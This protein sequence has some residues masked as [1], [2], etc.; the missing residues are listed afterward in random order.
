MSV[1]VDDS[2]GATS[3]DLSA[4][5]GEVF[6]FPASYAQRRLWF[7]DRYEPGSPL[8]NIPLAHRL[9]GPL[10]AAALAGALAEIVRRHEALRTTLEQDP[11]GPVQVVAPFSGSHP[12][13]W[14]D[15]ARLPAGSRQDEA[16]RLVAEE[17]SRPFDLERGPLFRTVLLRLGP[18]EHVLLANFHHAIADGWSLGVFH[19]ELAALYAAFRAGKPSPLADLPIQYADFSA[20]QQEWLQ[21][22]VLETQLAYW[23]E[24]LAGAPAVLELPSDPPRPAVR[25]HRGAARSLLLP[26]RLSGAARE[27]GHRAR[28]TRF[29][30]LL[31]AWKVLLQR[32]SGQ[33]DLVVGT[34]IA[35]RNQVETE[36]LIGLFVNTLALRTGLSGDPAFLEAVTRVRDT[37]LE[38]YAHQDLPFERLVEELRPERDLAH[39]PLVQVIFGLREPSERGLALPGLTAESAEVRHEAVK[40][41]LALSLE[42]TGAGLLARL[43]YSTDL[44]DGAAAT[45]WLESLAALLEGVAADPARPLGALPAFPE[46]S[47]HQMLVEWNDTWS[48]YPRG[49]TVHELFAAQVDRT[50]KA[51]AVESAEELL[52]YGEVNARANRLAHHLTG[53]GVGPE[54][55]VGLCLNRSVEA[56]VAVLGVLKAGGAYVPLDPA[57]PRERLAWMMADTA[58]PVLLS[59]SRHAAGLPE[60]GPG[61]RIVLLDREKGAIDRQSAGD[62]P[63][64]TAPEGLA[65]VMYTSGST[66]RSKGVAVCH[67]SVVR[68]VRETGYARFAGETFLQFAPIAF[69]ASTLE[70]WGPLLNGGRLAVFP[71]YAPSLAELGEAIERHGVTAL[72]LTAGLFHQM[73]EGPVASLRNVRQL[74]AGGDVLSPPHVAKALDEIPGVTLVNGYGP[75]ENTTF[76]C[77]YPMR[78]PRRSLGSVPVGRPIA[79]SRIALLDRN[80][81]P[82]PHGAP[83]E[84]CAGGDGLARGYLGRP[85]LTAEKFIPDPAASPAEPGARLYRTGDLARFRAD[86]SVE[87]LGRIDTQ[88]KVRGFRIELG[89]IEAHLVQHPAVRE[90]AVTAREDLPGSRRLVA[91]IVPLQPGRPGN[92]GLRD[93]LPAYLR[94]RLPEYMVPSAVVVMDALPL[95]ANGK[96]DR[97]ALPEPDWERSRGKGYAAP[98][99]PLEELLAGIFAEVL[100]TEAV[101][102]DDDFFGLGGHSL[103]ATQVI[104]RVRELCRVELPLRR[105]FEAPTVAGLAAHVE[106]AQRAERGAAPPPLVRAP[107][108]GHP[109]ASFAQERLWFLGRLGAG[110]ASYNVPG[111]FLLSGR[112]D[113]AALAAALN[114]V[115]RRHEALRATFATVEERVVQVVAPSL[116]LPL[117]FVDLDGLP[118]AG[119]EARRLA[120]AEARRTFDLARGPLVRTVLLRLGPREHVLLLTMHHIVS[121]GWSMGVLVRELSALYEAFVQG[122]PSPLPELPL[123]YADFAVWQRS[124]LRGEAL[125]AQLAYWRQR[126]AGAP[127]LLELPADRPRPA[128]QSFHGAQRSFALPSGLSRQLAEL[129]RRQGVTPFMALLAAFQALLARITGHLDL[130]V[131][132]PIANRNRFEIEGLIGFFVNT[133]VLRGDLSGDPGYGELLRRV[134]E[135]TLD[136]YTHQDLPFEKLVEELQPRRNLSHSPLFQVLFLLQN[137]PGAAP[138]LPEVALRQWEVDTGTAK[139]DL[140]LGLMEREEGLAG[141][142]EYNRDLF[143]ATTV[144]R[145]LTHFETLLAAAVAD[146]ERRLSALPLL[147]PAERHQ[148]L[149]EWNDTAAG[150]PRDLCVHQLF[151]ARVERA[152]EALAVIFEGERLTYAE[153]NRRANRLAHHLRALG[154]GPGSLVAVHLDRCAEMVVAVLG[155]LK[156]G[157]AYVPLESSWPPDRL[158]WIL[159]QKGIA[160]LLTQAGKLETV[161]SLPHLPALAHV[162]CLDGRPIPA[163]AEGGRLV[164]G[165]ALWTPADLKRRPDGDPPPAAGP[166]DRAYIIFTSG[167]T[168]T[169]KGVVVRHRPVVN[170]IHWVNRRFDVGPDDRVLFITNLSF[171]LSVYDIFGLLAAGGTVRVAPASEVRDP[172]RL[173]RILAEEPITFWDSAPAALQQLA[174]FFPPAGAPPVSTRLRLVFNSGDWIPVT[175]P[176][177]VR[178]CFPNV[179]FVSLGGATEATVWSNFYPIEEVS[180]WWASIPYGRPIENARYHVLDAGLEPCPPGV[181][182]DLYIGGECLSSGYDEPGLTAC[183]YIPDPFGEEPGGRL[184]KTGDR[185][186]TWA[187]GLMEFLGRVDTQVKV[188]GFR[189]ELGE[190]E[191]VLAGHPAVR[192]AVVLAREDTP[193]DQRLV[194]YLIPEPEQAASLPP[195]AELRRFALV[196]LPEYMVPSAYVWRESWP[197]SPT[198][199]LD[200]KALL[201][202]EGQRSKAEEPVAPRTRLERVIA[203]IWQEVIGVEAVGTRDN[204]F[205]LG[206]HSLLMARVH[207][208][209]EEALGREVAM[210][211]LFRYPTVGALAEA[212]GVGGI[213]GVE[214]LVQPAPAALPG[215]AGAA[216]GGTEIAVVGLAG[217]FPGARDVEELWR[218]LCAGVESIRFFSDEELIAAGFPAELLADPHVVKARG[219]LDDP[220]LF[221]AA[222]FDYPP[223]EAQVMDPQQRLFLECAWE[224]LENA[225]YDADGS[226]GRVGV[227]AGLSESAY[228]LDLLACPELVRSVGRHQISIANNR[229]YLPTRVSYKLN[230]RGPSVNVQSACSTS[231]VAVHLACLSLLHGAC[232]M[233]MAGGVSVQAREVSPYRYE[234]GGIASPDG[235]TR[236][237]DAR[238]QG[239]VSGSGVGVVVLKRLKDAL[240]DGDT[241]HAVIRGSASNNDGAAKVGFTAPSVDGQAAAIREALAAAGVPPETIGYVE[242]HGTGT[243]MGD[244]IEVAAL[245]Q[246]FGETPEEGSC[247]LGSIKTNIG[248]LD[249]ASG[250]AGLIKTVLAVERGQIPPSLHFE[251][252]N[253]RIDFDGSPFR[254]NDRLADW[255]ANGAPRRAGV[256]SF[257]IGGTN[258]HVVLEEAPAPEPA[259]VSRPAQLLLLSAKTPSALEAA[260]ARLAC[261]LEDRPGLSETELADA[262][263]TL[264]V[265]RKAFRHRRAVVYRGREEVV[266]ALR[267]LDPRRTMDGSPEGGDLPVVFLFPGQGAQ[268]PG[269]GG[270]LYRSEPVFAAALDRCCELLEPELGLDL[271]SVLHPPE[272]ES[273]EAAERLEQTAFTQPALFAV[274]YALAHL[275]MSWGLRPQA[276]LGHS[277]GEYV[278]ACLAGVF[279]LEEA[280]ALVAARGR[281]MQELPAGAMLA[282]SLPEEDLRPLL[283]APDR[284]GLDLAAVNGPKACVVAGEAEA[285]DGFRGWLEERGVE[286][287]RLHTSHAFHSRMM[288]PLLA[289]FE[290]RVR[291]VELHEPRIPY[292]SNVT[293]AW[294]TAAEAT[295][296]AYWARHLR[297]TVRFADGLA[298]LLRLPGPALLEVGPGRTLTTFARQHPEKGSARLVLP[299]LPHARDDRKDLDVL[300]GA[301]GRLWTAGAEVDWAGFRGGERRRRVP[302]PTYPFERRRF[303]L[304]GVGAP[305]AARAAEAPAPPAASEEQTEVER[306]IAEVWRD[307]LGVERVSRHDDFF[308]LGGSSLMAVQLGARLR[309]ALGVDLGSDFLLEASTL[310]ALAAIVEERRQQ[311]TEGRPAGPPRSSCLVRLQAGAPGRPPLFM[312]HQVG[313]NVYTFRALARVLG[314]DQPLYG[315]RSRG[316]EGEEEPFARIEEMAAHYLELIRGVQPRGPYRIGGASMGGMVAFEMAH[317]LRAAGEEVALLVLMDTPCLDQLPPREDDAQFVAGLFAGRVAL[318]PEELRPLSPDEQL[319]YA[320]DRARQAGNLPEGLDFDEARRLLRVLR[321]NAGALYDYAPRPWPGR[322]LFFRARERRPIDPPRPEIPWIE[323]AQGG[324]EILLVPGDHETMHAPPN[325][326]VAADRLKPLLA[327]GGATS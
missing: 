154:A 306:A 48:A 195:P 36:G 20:W 47:R 223:R 142:V 84:L 218:N 240:A 313:G 308:D 45:R 189:I 211:D 217:R 10:D 159:S 96:V 192:E 128:V 85:E 193:G 121:D 272:G 191:S 302:L 172:Q 31:A 9:H 115:V 41:D 148:V 166:D 61:V 118:D 236:A 139:L 51:T 299:S 238:A 37:C 213:A 19:R 201:P 25:S 267:G 224:A 147:A 136:A 293:G 265:G 252:P 241:I 99:G 22:E 8:Y 143:D 140:T 70:I 325:V 63:V 318:S 42:E 144:G 182:G 317:Q 110:G 29:M 21:G 274:E 250:V 98:R 186:R 157:A 214:D 109:P 212:L 161:E 286:C 251:R 106:A 35:G 268:Y 26:A 12:L 243:A 266:A 258:A 17:A 151:E 312:V 320:L 7:L 176:G 273:G 156:A 269:M 210:V 62:P 321:A 23:R 129:C 100:R 261:W 323:L 43:D 15:L 101:G 196:K 57:Y 184:Y 194:A 219:A 296:P 126:L 167:S 130:V 103:L 276:M 291:R 295:D 77:C 228:V 14:V 294:A 83:G 4:H 55:L 310:S 117:P 5:E 135:T 13:P 132:S 72:W 253:P 254:V 233:A 46:A 190:I 242:A 300:L 153:L 88:V 32:L 78:G 199:K 134:R 82:V 259:P 246:A 275:W 307:L 76:T 287:R 69:D 1:L 141:A 216:V 173:L 239:V 58:A 18:E 314:P 260:T 231:L 227:Y 93:E 249:A 327:G 204:F 68:L 74:L 230:L 165:A 284:A 304:D 114:E 324:V 278:A 235:H 75:T 207:A 169:P 107:R 183:K 247:A 215:Q 222:F 116:A 326:Q 206:G 40:F 229:D 282:V 6:A 105:L 316:L 108:R 297:E 232:D 200:R 244:P 257:G 113:P 292:L 149:R 170:L 53:L 256:S 120:A 197:L 311:V 198:G 158:H 27:A 33:D 65:Y 221:D 146:P 187:G 3:E 122:K 138:E 185:A 44:Y 28:A 38:A 309:E 305:P 152:P 181:P 264:Q 174:P 202:P 67:R 34:P 81:R 16:G 279:T 97:R 30:T 177:R 102:A 86:G 270:E 73:V 131:G 226:A 123:Q 245:R 64:R 315:L 180:P 60:P 49:A 263:H 52:T 281:L 168:G 288:A 301:L 137:A 119:A 164:V 175:L 179:R 220:D 80:L 171:D 111:A 39:A 79:N 322:L 290:E 2:P 59:D 95:N 188:R 150:Y 205:D 71:D 203:G 271:R 90:A 66:G 50:P 92:E 225:G 298:E 208:R 255:P 262:A 112:L 280:L 89:E 104:S 145:L 56:V 54:V 285:V 234:E 237:F 303:W 209:L 11:D 87:F 124:W 133:L 125:E 162:V 163:A 91:Y 277:I 94:G 289:A 248:H 127:E 319:A 155:I 24:R 283:E 178:E 160:H